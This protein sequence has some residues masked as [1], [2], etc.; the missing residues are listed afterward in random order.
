MLRLRSEARCA[1]LAAPLSMTIP[2][3]R[4]STPTRRHYGTLAGRA[5]ARSGRRF[6]SYTGPDVLIRSFSE[7]IN[8]LQPLLLLPL[9][10]RQVLIAGK[11]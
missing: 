10:A 11:G 9:A 5:W 1:L 4:F 3:V 6:A 8:L 7:W 2:R